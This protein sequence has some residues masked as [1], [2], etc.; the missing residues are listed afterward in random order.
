MTDES[1][2]TPP[3]ASGPSPDG[4]AAPAGEDEFA[5]IPSSRGRHPVIAV[6]TAALACFLIFQIR[7][8]LRYALSPSTAQ[9]LGDARGLTTTKTEALPINRTV[10]LAGHADRE[11]AVV[12]D[13]QG[14]WHFTQFF[15]LLGTNNR[16]FVRRASDPL[17]AEL[18]AHDVFVGRLMRFSDLSFQAAIRR[19]FAGHVSA[20]HFFAP[21]D[22]RAALAGA[23]GGALA[24]TDL[25]GDRVSLAANDELVIDL[26]RPGQM[27]VE[28]MRDRFSDQGKARAAVEQRGGQV[29]EAPG[30]AVDP[31]RLA[32]MVSF[33]PERRDQALQALGEMDRDMHIQPAHTTHKARVADLGATAE[34]IVVKTAGGE[35]QAFPLAQ[36]QGIG[37]LAA[38]QIPDDALILL[39]G[40][41]PG[42]H[43]KSLVIAAFL[44][45]FAVIN[46]L[47]LRRR[48]DW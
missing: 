34:A 15:R 21:A 27:R 43:L 8:D 26:D 41:R 19:H 11:S 9:D 44:L 3:P 25:L 46:L 33:P 10:R 16:I 20:T 1:K 38:V 48:G 28:F 4:P 29:I 37:T 18:A 7:D 6:G 35:T 47:A 32:L 12:L 5:G 40:E 13:T 17:P 45:G 14:S 2:T 31:K 36:I 22:V 30:D 23:S 39:E 24:L 42:E